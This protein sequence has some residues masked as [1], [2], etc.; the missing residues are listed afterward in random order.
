MCLAVALVGCG[1]QFDRLAVN[2]DLRAACPGITDSEI[3]FQIG[4]AEA[5]REQ[6]YSYA[7]T[8]E[9]FNDICATVDREFD[10]IICSHAVALQVY[11]S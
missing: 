6:G 7:E 8:L 5:L 4:Q 10:C 3:L 1:T 9:V 2:D 11:V